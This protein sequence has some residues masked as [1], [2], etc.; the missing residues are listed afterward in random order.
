MIK[1][2]GEHP[3]IVWL[4]SIVKDKIS[5]LERR[6]FFRIFGKTEKT[7][8][9]HST[10]MT[11][12]R[13]WKW[14]K[15]EGKTS[16]GCSVLTRVATNGS[17]L[18]LSSLP[19]DLF[20]NFVSSTTTRESESVAETSRSRF[21]FWAASCTEYRKATFNREKQHF[22]VNTAFLNLVLFNPLH[23]L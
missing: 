22:Q 17:S 18:G 4:K 16:I 2:L 8:L 13:Q 20:N 3:N 5:F 1:D 21:H 9:C 15:K 19:R 6:A 11:L 7:N 14:K 23:G 12:R 10:L